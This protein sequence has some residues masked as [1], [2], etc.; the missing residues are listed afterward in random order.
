MNIIKRVTITPAGAA[1]DGY[2]VPVDGRGMELLTALYRHTAGDYPKFFKM[3][4]LCRLGFV[5]TELLLDGDRRNGCDDRAV[6]LFNRNA[7]IANDRRYQATIPHDSEHF[8]PS[9]A[10]FV[11]TLPNIVTGEIAIRNRYYGETACYILENNDQ[12]IIE[13]I[14]GQAFDADPA[15][16]SAVAGWVDFNTEVDFLADI[17]LALKQ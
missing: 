9:P 1:I 11:Y 10:V 15:T 3:D 14:V 5:A 7:S 12:T 13:E 2:P 6:I 16:T 17:F 4:P 8:F